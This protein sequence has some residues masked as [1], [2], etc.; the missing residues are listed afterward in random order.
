M[1]QIIQGNLPLKIEMIKEQKKQ[2]GFLQIW[3]IVP[4]YC[5]FLPTT[6]HP[7]PSPVSYN[8]LTGQMSEASWVNL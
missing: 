7:A 6:M 8:I 2:L 1:A 5:F 3:V 4:L